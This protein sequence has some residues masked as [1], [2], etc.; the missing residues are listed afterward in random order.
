M[1]DDTY[2]MPAH[3]WTCFHCGETFTTPGSAG[4]HFGSMPDAKPGCLVRVSVGE[5]R[6][7]LFS[8]REAEQENRQLIGRLHDEKYAFMAE[9]GRHVEIELQSHTPFRNCRSIRD[10]F[11]EFDSMEG[12]ALAAEERVKT[13]E[14]EIATQRQEHRKEIR[15]LERDAREDCRASAA[16]ARWEAR[17]GDDYGSF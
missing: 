10:A 3:G 7:L 12:R 9:F 14:S 1:A 16:E 13:L 11:N 2:D 17:Q 6:G 8:L 4:Q 5:E 15:Q